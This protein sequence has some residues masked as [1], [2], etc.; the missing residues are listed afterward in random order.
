MIHIVILCLS[1]YYINVVFRL[2]SP[3]LKKSGNDVDLSL[4]VRG[5]FAKRRS[6]PTRRSLLEQLDQVVKCESAFLP[7]IDEIDNCLEDNREEY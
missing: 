4:W 5:G 7:S 6:A 3:P 2:H 1:N